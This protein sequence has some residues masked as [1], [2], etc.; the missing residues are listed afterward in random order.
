MMFLETPVMKREQIQTWYQQ[1][2]T[3]VLHND[4]RCGWV[5]FKVWSDG[6]VKPC[7]DLVVGD[8]ATQNFAEIWHGS[9][10]QQFREILDQEGMLPI[11][12]RC[13]LIVHR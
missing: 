4:V 1:P 7:R 8:M 10:Y 11:C 2:N 13:C 9:E 12:V 5:R 6:Q 3:Q